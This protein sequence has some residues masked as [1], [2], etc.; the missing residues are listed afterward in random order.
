MPMNLV[1]RKL[2]SSQYWARAVEKHGMPWALDGVPLGAHVLEIGPGFGATTRV[3]RKRVARLTAVEVDEASTEQ[4]RAEFGDTVRVLHGDGADLPLPDN[5]FDSVVCFTMLHHVPSPALQDRL[6]AEAQRVL[7]PG[8]VFAGSDSRT[9]FLFRQL[10]RG[11]TMV[12]VEPGGLPDRLLSAG[13]EGVSVLAKPGAFR[14][15]ARKPDST[16]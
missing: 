6:F 16:L 1:H 3:L 10:H 13:F 2:C 5:E 9:S 12:M 15:S 11:D 4:L 8:G 14:F 7:R